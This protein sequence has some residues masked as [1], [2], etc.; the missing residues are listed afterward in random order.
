M[1]KQLI[2]ITGPTAVGKTD[3][4]IRLAQELNT[5][6]V[7]C[8]SRQFYKEMSI[9]TAKPTPE[10]MDGVEHFFIDSHSIHDGLYTAGKYEQDA[11]QLLSELFQKYNQVILTGG[12][13]LYLHAIINGIDDL[14][15]VKSVVKDEIQALF[16]SQ[17]IEGLQKLLQEKDPEHYN[18]VDTHNH[19]RLIRALEVCL[20]SGQPYSSFLQQE[21]KK[22][23]FTVKGIVLNRD[24]EEL[25]DR[26]NRRVH[27]MIEMGLIEE[28]QALYD[29]KNH[30]ALRTV[31]YTEI[32]NWMDGVYSK[33]KA[34][35]M[36][37]Q[38]SRRY[39]KRQITW[40][41]REPGFQWVHP[42]QFTSDII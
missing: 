42:D 16:Q 22:R 3:L 30:S 29:Y 19:V 9:G 4:T 17:G 38:N 15:E 25:Y 34:I 32:F 21:N 6:I 36:I 11:I 8:D 40:F 23:D 26:I 14:P 41:K 20:S 24:R 10:E 13:G 37:Q 18:K 31:G 5:V 35:E 12:S 7:S 39:A 33:E 28:A 1:D 2:V 27:I